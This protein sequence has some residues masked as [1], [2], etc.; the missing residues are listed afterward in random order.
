MTT[1][2]QV[3]AP[4]AISGQRVES[5]YYPTPERITEILLN[6][7]PA[8][9]G[10]GAFEPCCGQGA[11]SNV[12]RRANCVVYES[13]I[14][15]QDGQE[16]DATTPSFWE[17]HCPQWV[18]TNPPFSVAEQILPHAFEAATLGVAFLLRL[19]YLEPTKN[20]SQW[21]QEHADRLRFVVPVNPR[22]QFRRDARGTDSCTCAWFVWDKTWSWRSRGIECPFV[23]ATGWRSN[24]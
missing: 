23:F 5:D 18:V 9:A 12:L 3:K 21:L 6:T 2:S 20:R 8:I 22:P 19:T 4:T 17:R 7:V 15:M 24:P 13:D 1:S 10:S 11:I 14:L 16:R